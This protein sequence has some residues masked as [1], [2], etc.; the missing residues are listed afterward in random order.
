VRS[1]GCPLRADSTT[2]STTSQRLQPFAAAADRLRL[3]ADDGREV[4]DLVDQWVTALECHG[5]RVEG[6]PP[7]PGPGEDL[8]V[9]VGTDSEPIDP[10]RW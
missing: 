8:Q 6:L 4:L 5:R 7:R 2:A 9:I 1:T 3:A 10:A